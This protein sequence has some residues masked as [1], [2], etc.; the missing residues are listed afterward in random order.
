VQKFLR[1]VANRQTD[2]Q[3]EKQRRLY[4]LLI[5][6][7]CYNKSLCS[8]KR[9]CKDDSGSITTTTITV[10]RPFF[11]GPSGWAGARR[12]LLD[13]MVQG[14]IIRGRRTDDPARC[15]S[16]WTNQSPPPPSPHFLQAGCPSCRPTNS[17]KAASHN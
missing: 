14:K 11:R 2:V 16:I 4:I 13:F 9:V 8:L 15:H 7:E 5:G 10:L 1:K 6:G 17:V 3:T 12:K